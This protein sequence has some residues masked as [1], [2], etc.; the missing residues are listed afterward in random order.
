MIKGMFS[1]LL[2]IFPLQKI[3]IWHWI[4]SERTIHIDKINREVKRLA[5]ITIYVP[6]ESDQTFY[7][8]IVL[9]TWDFPDLTLRRP[10][11]HSFLLV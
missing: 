6:T 3:K 4:Y 11:F 8:P 10:F 2:S 9:P 7:A 5:I 1:A